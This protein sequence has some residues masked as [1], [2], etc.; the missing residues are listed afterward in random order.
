ML[1]EDDAAL[2]EAL[3]WALSVAGFDLR[4]CNSA[5]QALAEVDTSRPHRLITDL[6]LPGADG[7]YL[8]DE[9][10]QRTKRP[11]PTLLISA[12]ADPGIARRVA[13]RDHVTFAAKPVS[14]DRIV[15]WLEEHSAP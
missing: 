10:A 13:R 11:V 12:Q 5:E 6:R 4:V 3:R 9:I 15:S 2:A 8:A 14:V 1:V 7:L